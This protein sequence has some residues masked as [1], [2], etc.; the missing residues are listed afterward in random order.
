MER[1]ST[2]ITEKDHLQSVY[3]GATVELV[4]GEEYEGKLE[5]V[6]DKAKRDENLLTDPASDLTTI[7]VPKNLRPKHAAPSTRS[8]TMSTIISKVRSSIKSSLDLTTPST[9]TLPILS[10]TD[11]ALDSNH[12]HVNHASKS[13]GENGKQMEVLKK[14]RPKPAVATANTLAI[15]SFAANE[16]ATNKSTLIDKGKAKCEQTSHKKPTKNSR[17]KRL[18]AAHTANK[19]ANLTNKMDKNENTTNATVFQ[20]CQR[21]KSQA[22]ISNFAEVSQENHLKNNSCAEANEA[23]KD[24]EK[25]VDAILAARRMPSDG[26]LRQADFGYVCP[27]KKCYT[28]FGKSERLYQHVRKCHGIISEKITMPTICF[29]CRKAY[30]NSKALKMHNRLQHMEFAKCPICKKEIVMSGMTDHIHHHNKKRE[31]PKMCDLCGKGYKNL[32]K[33]KIIMHPDTTKAIKCDEPFCYKIFQTNFNLRRHQ[34]KMHGSHPCPDCGVTF[35]N[36]SE[37][38]KHKCG[39]KEFKKV[40]KA[41]KLEEEKTKAFVSGGKHDVVDN[42]KS[43]LSEKQK[44]TLMKFK[45]DLKLIEGDDS[46]VKALLSVFYYVGKLLAE[47]EPL[48]LSPEESKLYL[49]HNSYRFLDTVE[50]LKPYYKRLV[51][52][53]KNKDCVKSKSLK[54]RILQTIDTG[55]RKKNF[56]W[57]PHAK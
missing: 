51:Q 41:A 20:N 21:V 18:A 23:F 17:A 54:I 10:S 13:G 49:H 8:A 29:L 24:K 1:S 52:K 38:T 11:E 56:A 43:R 30:P 35:R 34:R 16:H 6:K 28:S 57:W 19:A 36:Q 2:N 25:N 40:T 53:I 50:S 15:S 26:K 9:M 39:D 27:V 14:S 48:D 31:E 7:S 12:F 46:D 45:T 42:I 3:F 4:A 55:F 22:K 37:L 32:D 5:I 47:F 44:E 33:H